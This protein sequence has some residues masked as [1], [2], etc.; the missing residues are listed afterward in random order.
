MKSDTTD[1]M[2]RLYQYLVEH[3]WGEPDDLIIYNGWSNVPPTI[4]PVVHVAIWD[5]N[6]DCDVTTFATLG[7]SEGLMSGVD[8]RAEL[9]LGYRGKLNSPVRWSLSNFVANVTEYPFMN[10]LALDWWQC[11]NNPGV[12]PGFPGCTNL[13]VAPTFGD[14]KF[15][16]FPEPD[17]NVKLLSL[18]PITPRENRILVEEGR[19]AFLDYWESSGADIFAPRSDGA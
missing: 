12:I 6:K 14:D 2:K 17:H 1:R 10:G 3:C 13:L 4:L 16:H 8:Y 19:S 9:T 5:A 18:V 11:L 15:R 7:M